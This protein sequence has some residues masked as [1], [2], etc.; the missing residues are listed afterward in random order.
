MHA[1]VVI[2]RCSRRGQVDDVGEVWVSGRTETEA[3]SKASTRLGCADG[4]IILAQVS[5]PACVHA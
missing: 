2:L 5:V 3:R 4:D 1:R